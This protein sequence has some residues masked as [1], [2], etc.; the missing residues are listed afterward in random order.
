MIL[1]YAYYC[2]DIIHTGHLLAMKNA[3]AL[4]GKDG[5]LI[6]GILTDNAIMEKKLKPVLSFEERMYI[7]QCL[8]F[9][10]LVV[11]QETYSNI[12]NL[13]RFKPDITIESDSHDIDH[14]EEV[15]KLVKNWNGR[16]IIMPYYPPQSS[17]NIK[18]TIKGIE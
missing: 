17:S 18:T 5:K 7:A 14:I 16:V 12:P 3:K 13:L 11:A 1:V 4:I 15:R 10:D 6:I 2:L 8:K 9:P